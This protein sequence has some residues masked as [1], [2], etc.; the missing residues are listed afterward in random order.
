MH[1]LLV[2]DKSDYIG[3]TSQMFT[4]ARQSDQKEFIIG[5]ENDMIYRLKK[6]VP[7]KDFYPLRETALCTNMKKITLS[8]LEKS[9]AGK[10]PALEIDPDLLK[11]AKLPIERMVKIL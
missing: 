6:L 7:D 11:K 9:L 1:K 3:S 2:L 8:D 5:T 4:I 10:V